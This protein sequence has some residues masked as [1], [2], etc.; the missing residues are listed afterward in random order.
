MK[1]LMLV[2]LLPFLMSL[3]SCT[4]EKIIYQ[5]VYREVY[6]TVPMYQKLETPKVNLKVW[7]DYAIYKEQCEAIISEGN[8]NLDSIYKSLER[9]K[10]EAK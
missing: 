10:D 9:S 6:P 3:S 7:G 5:V 2:L 8:L 4:D 1:V